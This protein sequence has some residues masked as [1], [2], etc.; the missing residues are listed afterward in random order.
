MTTGLG[1]INEKTGKLTAFGKRAHDEWYR[2]LYSG[3]RACGG[4]QPSSDYPLSDAGERAAMADAR[5]RSRAKITTE[6]GDVRSVMAFAG[7]IDKNGSAGVGY[8]YTFLGG[9]EIQLYA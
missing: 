2:S 3:W 4:S 5:R 6:S 7:R 9:K 1:L 8:E